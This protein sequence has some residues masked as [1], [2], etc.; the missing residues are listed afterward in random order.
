MEKDF[1]IQKWGKKDIGFHQKEVN[2]HLKTN[3]E[4]LSLKKGSRIFLP[5]CGKTLDI[6]WLLS[7]GY[8]VVGAELV[9]TA[10][11]ELFA[12]LKIKP[13]VTQINKSKHYSAQ[14][15]DIFVGDLFDLS[16]EIL[17]KV[18][19]IYDRAALVALPIELR[20]KYT[21]HLWQITDRAPQLLV[22]YEYN[23]SEMPGPPFSIKEEEVMLHYANTYNIKRIESVEVPGGMRG[24][25]FAKEN[26]WLL[27]NK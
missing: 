3:L 22:V 1:W 9:E 25:I 18:D 5:L 13:Q 11:Q 10:I 19:A 4:K 2:A 24:Q 23:Q 16:K 14:N 12:E 21:K 7:Q 26:V 17:G 6:G 15:I 20:E 8:R 27:V